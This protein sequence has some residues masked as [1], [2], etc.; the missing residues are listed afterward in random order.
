M[1]EKFIRDYYR[2][3]AGILIE[4]TEFGFYKYSINEVKSEEG[5]EKHFWIHE[6]YIDKEHRTIKNLTKFSHKIHSLAYETNCTHICLSLNNTW[7]NYEKKRRVVENVFGYECV[8][9]DGVNDYFAR[10]L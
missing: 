2:E 9:S 5:N 4:C 1:F 10:S 6:M 7:V 8:G 3:Y